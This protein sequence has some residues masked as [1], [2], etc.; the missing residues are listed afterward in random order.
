MHFKKAILLLFT[1]TIIACGGD[2]DKS[3]KS[4]TT[5][6]IRS[7]KSGLDWDSI[8][9]K[10]NPRVS[11]VSFDLVDIQKINLELFG[12][13]KKVNLSYSNSIEAGMGIIKIYSVWYKSS[14]NI[15]IDMEDDGMGLLTL[16][17]SGSYGCS[18]QT[19]N[20]RISNLEGLCHVYG[21]LILPTGKKIEVSNENRLISRRFIAIDNKSLLES[22]DRA[23]F[24]DEKLALINDYLKS[25]KAINAK[26]TISS[27]ELGTIISEFSW[28]DE[29]YSVLRKLH[30]Y[31][32][33]RENLEQMIENEFSHFE[34]EEALKI[35]AK[36]SR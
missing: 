9:S 26:P 29:K 10:Y 27:L 16:G 23:S 11:E 3:S 17:N 22:L 18:I 5:E 36:R 24:D 12:L 33:D 8:P 4:K 2:S 34:R 1:S 6:Q 32:S 7:A 30:K 31:T 21:E 20:R 14:S 15:S 25:Y 35:I 13:D 28:A 19:R